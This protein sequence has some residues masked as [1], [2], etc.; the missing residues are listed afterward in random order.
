L[1]LQ[2]LISGRTVYVFHIL[3][4]LAAQSEKDKRQ[5]PISQSNTV[6]T[7]DAKSSRKRRSKSAERFYRLRINAMDSLRHFGQRLQRIRDRSF[8]RNRRSRSSQPV[9][10]ESRAALPQRQHSSDLDSNQFY[11]Y[12]N[13]KQEATENYTIHKYFDSEYKTK[14][15]TTKDTFSTDLNTLATDDRTLARFEDF[16]KTPTNSTN[17]IRRRGLPKDITPIQRYVDTI[18]NFDNLMEWMRN[19][20][21]ELTHQ[22]VHT[23]YSAFERQREEYALHT[24]KESQLE[25]CIRRV[26][27]KQVIVEK[28]EIIRDDNFMLSPIQHIEEDETIRQDNFMLSPIQHALPSIRPVEEEP[29]QS[30]HRILHG[31]VLPVSGKISPAYLLR[32]NST[33]NAGLTTDISQEWSLQKD[34]NFSHA[35]A[36]FIPYAQS[37]TE[38]N[39]EDPRPKVVVTGVQDEKLAELEDYVQRQLRLMDRETQTT[40]RLR[41]LANQTPTES[42]ILNEKLTTSSTI[43]YDQR[44][45]Q[46]LPSRKQGDSDNLTLLKQTLLEVE[47]DAIGAQ[48]RFHKTMSEDA[49]LIEKTIL[50]VSEELQ[51]RGPLSDAQLLASEELLRSK[52]AEAILNLKPSI[53]TGYDTSS[54][55]TPTIDDTKITDH[56]MEQIDILRDPILTL[57]EKLGRLEKHL[58]YDEEESIREEL[59]QINSLSDSHEVKLREKSVRSR[60]E[61]VA[62][63][64]PLI[65]LVKNKLSHLNS[66][67]DQQAAAKRSK[68]PVRFISDENSRSIHRLL[69]NIGEEVSKIHTLCRE[70][71]KID[72]VNLVVEVLAK[73]CKSIDAILEGF[74]RNEDLS[75]MSTS[76]T[77]SSQAPATNVTV[78]LNK[79]EQIEETNTL[80][81]YW[82]GGDE[83]HNLSVQVDSSLSKPE[84]AMTTNASVKVQE[85][86]HVKKNFDAAVKTD[87]VFKRVE[88]REEVPE[89]KLITPSL[90]AKKSKVESEIGINVQ[91]KSEV[92]HVETLLVNQSVITANERIDTPP[93]KVKQLEDSIIIVRRKN[94]EFSSPTENLIDEDASVSENVDVP[95]L[96]ATNR[97]SLVI[98]TRETDIISSDDDTPHLQVV[99]IQNNVWEKFK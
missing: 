97:S 4:I 18:C 73:V 54:N 23:T 21:R 22:S 24:T 3:I 39:V 13:P 37:R 19:S 74:H 81:M 11:F 61:S 5:G 34:D 77:I 2:S 16:Y 28:D 1:I 9:P 33:C 29:T 53:P 92:K 72:S 35:E 86:A 82:S 68:T 10:V 62:R 42:P 44:H 71:K 47:R 20:S 70:N 55:N 7:P 78:K 14:V 91:N 69:L 87:V 41:Q 96:F 27:Q 76:L 89:I 49:L 84:M 40:P 36:F 79:P 8:T 65:V 31:K 15:I 46:T 63:M 59:Q 56:Q 45:F 17:T 95:I 67:V 64:T 25:E 30:R 57:K 51:K 60:T 52:I 6:E 32:T 80:L 12:N 85:F 98:P 75:E 48:R 50:K 88:N 83:T 58:I 90:A 43:K 38:Q 66:A 26:E 93:L 94:A 99:D